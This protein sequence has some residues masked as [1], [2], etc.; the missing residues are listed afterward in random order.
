M[1]VFQTGNKN[2]EAIC[3]KGTFEKEDLK[4]T[5]LPGFFQEES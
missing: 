2:K 1:C 5:K 4:T 3:C